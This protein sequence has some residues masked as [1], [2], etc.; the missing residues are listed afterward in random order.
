M[1][2]L[3]VSVEPHHQEDKEAE[4]KATVGAKYLVG[5]AVVFLPSTGLLGRAVTTA[6]AVTAGVVDQE[7][8]HTSTPTGEGYVRVKREGTFE[9][10]YPAGSATDAL[11]GDLVEWVDDNNVQTKATGILAGRIV[12]VV[13][14]T[15][16][17]VMLAA[18]TI[19]TD[20]D[21]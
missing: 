3:T 18:K 5:G 20:T 6:N 13:S 19:D 9:F 14:A 7:V 8:D 16:V 1:S 10:G 2:N 4:F 12:K 21:T 15:R 11:V 17:R